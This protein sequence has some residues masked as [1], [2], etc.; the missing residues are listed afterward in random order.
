MVHFCLLVHARKI[1]QQHTFVIHLP[2]HQ[3]NLTSDNASPVQAAEKDLCDAGSGKFC[4]WHQ[5]T[6]G[7]FWIKHH[8]V[9]DTSGNTGPTV[10][11]SGSKTG[12][13]LSKI[14]HDRQLNY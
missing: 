3:F 14:Y 8:G 1:F 10:D 6:D 5:E 2:F 9:A 11:S 12:E 13:D 7:L 4:D